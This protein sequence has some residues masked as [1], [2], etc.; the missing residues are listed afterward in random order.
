MGHRAKLP[1]RYRSQ[2][3]DMGRE[4]M[5]PKTSYAT[6]PL[7]TLLLVTILYTVVHRLSRHSNGLRV[8]MAEDTCGCY[9]GWSRIVVLHLLSGGGISINSEP[10]M[11][12]RLASRLQTIYST[13]AE[14]I[15]Y[16][17]A[18]DDIPFQRVAEAIDLVQGVQEESLQGLTVPKELQGPGRRMNIQIRLITP[19]AIN[20]PC[21]VN[22]FNWAKQGLP[23]SQ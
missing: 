3:I 15:L 4:S 20:K 11:Q 6:V 18:E 19:K 21:P 1:Y 8:Q 7:A 16:L 5:R 22:C 12:T 2:K 17:S 13:R 10:T 23:I 9:P 14:R